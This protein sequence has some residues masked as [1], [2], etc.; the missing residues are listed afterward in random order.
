MEFCEAACNN[1]PARWVHLQDPGSPPFIF[2][3]VIKGD[4]V[5]A[6]VRL[7]QDI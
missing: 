5:C 7:D 6:I 3:G 2:E 1:V 4:D